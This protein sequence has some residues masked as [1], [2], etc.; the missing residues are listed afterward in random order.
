[1]A[2][3]SYYFECPCGNIYDDIVQG[4]DGRPDPCTKCGGTKAV[5][6]PSAPALAKERIPMYPG[7]KKQM[8]GYGSR[9]RRPAEKGNTQIS[10]PR[11]KPG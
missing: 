8:A 11:K 1:M 5:R 2:W 3:L 7:N 4:T 9:L 10:V 6:L